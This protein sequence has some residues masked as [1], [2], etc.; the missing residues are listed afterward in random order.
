[1]DKG[2]KMWE[3]NKGTNEKAGMQALTR[4]SGKKFKR[5]Q[6]NKREIHKDLLKDY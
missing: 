6:K 2:D 5:R 4:A 3:T 1:M